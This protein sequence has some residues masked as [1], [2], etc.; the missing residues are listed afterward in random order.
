MKT[1]DLGTTN[2]DVA[3]L[4]DEARSDDVVVRL[5]DG[6]EFLLIAI[7]EFDDEIARSRSNPKLMALLEE[8]A[9]QATTIPLSEVKRRLQL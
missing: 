3:R 9:K 2:L 6:S 5:P 7:N 8:R 1:V 4:L